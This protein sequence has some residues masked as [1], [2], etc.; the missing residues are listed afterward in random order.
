MS[1]SLVLESTHAQELV[2][3]SI[4]S[5]LWHGGGYTNEERR[6][7]ISILLDIRANTDFEIDD[8]VFDIAIG[9]GINR[10]RLRQTRE[11]T[12]V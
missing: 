11:D 7:L 12:Q 2:A 5:A 8:W 6:Y 3:R 4:Q 9:L 1:T 10:K